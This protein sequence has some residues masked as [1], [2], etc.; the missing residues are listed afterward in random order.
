MFKK[1]FGSRLPVQT[2][3]NMKESRTGKGTTM[4][5]T[6]MADARRNARMWQIIALVSLSF[7]PISLAINYHAVNLPRT[8]PVIVT[9]NQEGQATYVGAVDKNYWNNNRIPEKHKIY[10]IKNLIRNMYTISTD[11]NSQL[12]YVNTSRASVQGAAVNLLKEFEKTHNPF[13]YFG[14]RITKVDIQEPLQQTDRTYYV[15]FSVT[16][17]SATGTFV[18]EEPLR[19]LFTIDYFERD[20]ELNP[21]GVYITNFDIKDR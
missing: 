9:V 6:L 14:S 1:S 20:N 7:F 4:M 11:R 3:F 16:T 15:D 12:E 19:G 13:D 10:Q 21:L 18:S 2:P 17:Y 5:Q 8:V